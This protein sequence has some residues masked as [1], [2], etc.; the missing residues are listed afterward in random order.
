MSKS[1]NYLDFLKLCPDGP[2]T[3]GDGE[4]WHHKCSNAVKVGQTEVQRHSQT[5]S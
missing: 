2:Q 5:P 1:T 3:V 4:H